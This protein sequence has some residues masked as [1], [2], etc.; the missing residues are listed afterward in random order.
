MSIKQS[1]TQSRELSQQERSELATCRVIVLHQ[2]RSSVV[3]ARAQGGFIL[4]SVEIPRCQ[5]VAENLTAA[6]K[7]KWCC[8]V[9]CLFALP[10]RTQGNDSNHANYQVTEGA[11]LTGTHDSGTAWVPICSLSQ[12]RFEDPED[13]LSIQECL[14]QCDS[15]QTDGRAPFARKNWFHQLRTWAGEVIHPMGLALT[16]R[17]SQLNAGPSFSLIRF[18]TDRTA[19]WFKAVGEPNRREFKITVQLAHEFPRHVAQVLGI[20]PDWNGWLSPEIEGTSLAETREPAC[21]KAAAADLARLQVESIG[22]VRR[23]EQLGARDFRIATLADKV[24]PFLEVVD[25][26]REH[27]APV[28][29]P[30]L[31]QKELF[32]LGVRVQNALNRLEEIRVPATLGHLDLNPGNIIFCQTGCVFLD[33]AEAYV[34]NPFLSFQYL[35]EHFRRAV[36]SEPEDGQSLQAGYA[37]VWKE[38]ISENKVAEALEL[39]PLVAVFAYAAADIGT[40]PAKAGCGAYLCSLT[41]RMQREANQMVERREKSELFLGT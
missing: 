26:L 30:I 41:R 40:Q 3:L 18:E 35:L 27:P 21:W 25:Q 1:V 32:I 38:V 19:I 4:P 8:E 11:N 23:I 15:Y 22:K 17:F 29:P 13:Y 10:G 36:G 28:A 7:S 34:G 16:G 31:S 12:D 9:V 39:A 6:M 14:K 37:A 2:D 20:R 33:W 5:R 24:T